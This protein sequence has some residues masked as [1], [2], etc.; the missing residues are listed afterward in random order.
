MRAPYGEVRDNHFHILKA[1][2]DPIDIDAKQI[3]NIEF[4]LTGKALNEFLYQVIFSITC[5]FLSLLVYFF[6]FV[7]HFCVH[8]FSS[9]L[10]FSFIFFKSFDYFDL[11]LYMVGGY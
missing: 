3:P 4:G 9:L 10:Q 5:I 11:N 7:V 2:E 6:V 8:L 1:K